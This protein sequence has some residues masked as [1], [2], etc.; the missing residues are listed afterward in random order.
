M[1][2]GQ[3]QLNRGLDGGILSFYYQYYLA[4]YN[5]GSSLVYFVRSK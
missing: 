3:D 5:N 4:G 2:S 1:P